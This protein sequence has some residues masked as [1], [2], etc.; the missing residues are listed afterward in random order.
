MLE[1]ARS[2]KFTRKNFEKTKSRVAQKQNLVKI[3]AQEGQPGVGQRKYGLF[4]NLFTPNILPVMVPIELISSYF[5]CN[6]LQR[7]FLGT[8]RLFARLKNRSL[9][10]TPNNL[11][12]RKIKP[13]SRPFFFLP[14]P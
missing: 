8:P 1:R 5:E 13:S 14:R 6:G 11:L 10:L 4:I 12:A 9:Q 2:K 3:I 7:G